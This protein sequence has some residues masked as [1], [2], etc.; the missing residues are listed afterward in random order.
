MLLEEYEFHSAEKTERPRT[1]YRLSQVT[2]LS[3]T[4]SDHVVDLRL[5]KYFLET[6]AKLRQRP[7]ISPCV[8]PFAWNNSALDGRIF[9]KFDI[10]EF[11]ENTSENF[12]FDLNTTRIMGKKRIDVLGEKREQ[13]T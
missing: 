8:R 7:L 4:G 12:K 1:A 3:P 13:R 11:F 5:F 10:W 2:V 6:F 9:M